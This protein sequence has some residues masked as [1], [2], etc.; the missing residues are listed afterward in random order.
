MLKIDQSIT[1]DDLNDLVDAFA[2]LKKRFIDV[3][4]SEESAEKFCL[5]FC[6]VWIFKANIDYE[7]ELNRRL[8]EKQRRTKR[9]R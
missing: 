3:G 6:K 2:D 9:Q 1:V 4:F 5:E 8:I 7:A